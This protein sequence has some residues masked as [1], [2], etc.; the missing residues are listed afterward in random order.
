[1]LDQGETPDV[2]LM[3]IEKQII[4]VTI[5][6]AYLGG[7]EMAIP[8]TYC[9]VYAPL[10]IKT[11][12]SMNRKSSLNESL[13]I[14]MIIVLSALWSFLDARGGDHCHQRVCCESDRYHHGQ[15]LPL[16]C[17]IHS[18]VSSKFITLIII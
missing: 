4:A 6:N 5:E 7:G 8:Y 15:L 14:N 11:N 16:Y 1:M 17:R 13:Y 10:E 9:E 2:P 18:Q 12:V 3:Y